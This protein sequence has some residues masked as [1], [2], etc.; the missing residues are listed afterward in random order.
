MKLL[1]Y[2]L[3]LNRYQNNLET[4]MRGSDFIFGCVHLFHYKFHKINPNSGGSYIH[5]PDQIKSN[6]KATI[7]H[8]NKKDNKSF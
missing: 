1:K 3:N 5:S 6:N 4:S 8:T 7:S 2:F